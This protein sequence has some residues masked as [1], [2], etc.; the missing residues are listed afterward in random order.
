MWGKGLD[1]VGG[2]RDVVE[3]E[4]RCC[5][6]EGRYGGLMIGCA[7]TGWKERFSKIKGRL[8]INWKP[9]ESIEHIKSLLNPSRSAVSL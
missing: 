3:R 9:L 2:G 7:Y 6:E 4:I 8:N 1:E 5:G